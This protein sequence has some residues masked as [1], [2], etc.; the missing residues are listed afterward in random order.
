MIRVSAKVCLGFCM[1]VSTASAWA[2]ESAALAPK[3]E[4]SV[5]KIPAVDRAAESYFASDSQRLI[6]NAKFASDEAF[7][8]YT[9][10]LDGSELLRINDLGEDAC[11]F[12]FPSGERL[13]FTS[14]RD[15]L[16]MTKGD[17]SDSANYPQGAELY[18]AAL[19]GSKL[20]RLTN[21]QYYD[22]EVSVSPNGQ[23][24]LFTRQIE[25]HL[26]L[27]RMRADGTGEQQVTQ[28]DDWQKGGAF[29][30][31]DSHTIVYRAWKFADEG[32]RG[33]AMDI[34]LIDE[35][36]GNVRR[37]TDDG[38]V[39]WSPYPAPDGKHLVFVKMLPPHNFDLFLLNMETK[40]Q[41]QL[42]QFEGFDGFPSFSPDGKKLSFSSSRAAAPGE[43]KLSLFVMD[44]SSLHLGSGGL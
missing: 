28:R 27:W 20:Q 44:V 32:K 37:L 18:T 33:K 2:D 39:N 17:W 29:Y 10:K 25:G 38:G 26:D 7:H 16:G 9:A 21:N 6:F 8:T 1:C 4:L 43:R 34:F 35:D 13:I 30:L 24:I 12:F 3:S 19:D 31:P 15:N 40:A 36:G 41:Q 14:T 42:T 22:A 5:T 11:S 23:S